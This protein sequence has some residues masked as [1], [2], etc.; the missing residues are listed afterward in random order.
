MEGRGGGVGTND[1]NAGLGD[2]SG[3]CG[4]GRGVS[5]CNE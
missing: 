4:M 2:Y 1:P 3:A 5:V